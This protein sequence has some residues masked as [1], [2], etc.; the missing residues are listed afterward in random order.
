[1]L[2]FPGHGEMGAGCGDPIHMFCH[3]CGH[4]F[5]VEHSCMRR[6]CPN[7]YTNWAG[8]EGAAAGQRLTAYLVAHWDNADARAK[9]RERFNAARN[10]PDASPEEKKWYTLQTY[11]TVISYESESVDRAGDVE[12]I[13]KKAYG[14]AKAHGIFGGCA[15]LH[16][17]GKDDT[18]THVHVIGIAGYIRPARP[19]MGYVFKVIPHDGKW[20]ARRQIEREN[21]VKY[22]LTHCTIA[23]D[24]HAITWFGCLAYN[25]FSSDIV[26]REI[27]AGFVDARDFEKCCP[28]CGSNNV[29]KDFEMDYTGWP[30]VRVEIT[31]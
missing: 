4:W 12:K 23:D 18:G 30:A 10:N 8:R 24:L 26:R 27:D 21:I 13:R 1:M 11:H 5:D 28:K 17:R 22:A 16:S 15:I 2:T 20:Y 9:E 6:E 31:T 19:D 25:K 14:H 3:D 29:S 7:C